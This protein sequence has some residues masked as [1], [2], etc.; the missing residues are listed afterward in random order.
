MAMATDDQ[1]ARRA[2]MADPDLKPLC[3]SMSTTIWKKNA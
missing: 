2:A 1:T 3:D